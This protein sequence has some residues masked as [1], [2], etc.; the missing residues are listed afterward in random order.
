MVKK[1]D[2]FLRTVNYYVNYVLH[3]MFNHNGNR[4][5]SVI[6]F[7]FYHNLL[8]YNSYIITLVIQN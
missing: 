4:V 8:E 3:I 6:G 7:R 5:H 1:N 2:F